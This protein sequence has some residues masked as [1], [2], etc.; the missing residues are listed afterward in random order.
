MANKNRIKFRFFFVSFAFSSQK[1][2]LYFQRFAPE[3]AILR[4]NLF[5]K[6]F[7]RL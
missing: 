3:N 2:F 5:A 1:Y 4:K 7:L 6:K